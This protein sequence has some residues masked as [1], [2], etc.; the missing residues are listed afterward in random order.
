MASS[1]TS[2]PPFSITPVVLVVMALGGC[3]VLPAGDPGASFLEVPVLLED[4]VDPFRG[5]E[6]AVVAAA[7]RTPTGPHFVVCLKEPSTLGAPLETLAVYEDPGAA[8]QDGIARLDVFF[9]VPDDIVAV[10]TGRAPQGVVATSRSTIWQADR[11]LA[12]VNPD[13]VPFA[14]SELPSLEG[15]DFLTGV[16]FVDSPDA[17]ARRCGDAAADGCP[18]ECDVVTGEG[19]APCCQT[20]H[21]AFHACDALVLDTLFGSV[22]VRLRNLG[23]P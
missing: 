17:A 15:A 1:S 16:V 12:D 18:T 9:G 22:P 19:A 3:S 2:P 7:W 13:A 14:L 5:G 21:D 8:L 6:E 4:P 10:A 20:A 11:N 23:P